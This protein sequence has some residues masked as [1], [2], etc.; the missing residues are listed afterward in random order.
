M[1]LPAILAAP[2]AMQ[3]L[4][5]GGAFVA[6]AMLAGGQRGPERVDM[7]TEDAL[8]RLPDGGDLRLDPA[9]GRADAEGRWRRTL[10]LR[11]GGPGVTVDLAGLARLRVRRAVD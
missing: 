5:L 7:A 3:L 6:G 10:R 2:A 4:T 11:A 1:P 8:D 9:N